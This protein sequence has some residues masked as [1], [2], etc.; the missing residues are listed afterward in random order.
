MPACVSMSRSRGGSPSDW[1]PLHQHPEKGHLT[2]PFLGNGEKR[3]LR[4]GNATNSHKPF[5]SCKDY[6]WEYMN[7]NS[8]LVT[9][10]NTVNGTWEVPG[11]G[12]LSDNRCSPSAAS[13]YSLQI[14]QMKSYLSL[15][16]GMFRTCWKL[17]QMKATRNV[18][19]CATQ[20]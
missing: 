12:S 7:T 19:I 17:M 1:E 6:S 14:S 10:T 18:Y 11:G 4:H 13:S 3:I 20:R 8:D 2:K 5:K 9:W 16:G 15:S